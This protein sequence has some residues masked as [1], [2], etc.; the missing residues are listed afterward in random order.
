M[1]K[2]DEEKMVVTTS[3]F[4]V[5]SFLSFFFLIPRKNK[6][7]SIALWL[8]GQEPLPYFIGFKCYHRLYVAVAIDVV[9]VTVI[10]CNCVIIYF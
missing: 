1:V 7:G 5:F 3:S 9:H 8:P 6:T 10:S 2:N 4:P